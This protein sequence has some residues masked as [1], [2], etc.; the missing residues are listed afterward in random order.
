MKT[1]RLQV[2]PT[3]T[4]LAARDHKQAHET[5]RA[6][7]TFIERQGPDALAAAVVDVPGTLTT[8]AKTDMWF[9]RYVRALRQV[10]PQ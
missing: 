6:F 7:A 5:L 1:H 9:R 2:V 3:P 10:E 4:T 8:V